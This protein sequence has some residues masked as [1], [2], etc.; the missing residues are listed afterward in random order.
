L[1]VAGGEAGALVPVVPVP[2]GGVADPVPEPEA[3]GDPV[4]EP[5]PGGDPVPEPEAGGAVGGLVAVLVDAG[6]EG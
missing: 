5:E 6:G 2:V 3:G 4:P 1:P